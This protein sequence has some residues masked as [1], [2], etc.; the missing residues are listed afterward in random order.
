MIFK[1][2]VSG[3]YVMVYF[4]FFYVILCIFLLKWAGIVKRKGLFLNS[5]NVPMRKCQCTKNTTTDKQYYPD[6]QH[7]LIKEN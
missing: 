6:C 4:M 7:E 5:K 1:E 2:G 3:K